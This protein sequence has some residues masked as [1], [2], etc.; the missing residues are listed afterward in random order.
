[1]QSETF[2]TFEQAVALKE[3]GFD[4][5]CQSYYA[6][7]PDGRPDL[8]ISGLGTIS[9]LDLKGRDTLAPTQA[10]AQKWLRDVKGVHVL[11]TLESVNRPYYVCHITQLHSVAKR[12]TDDVKYFPTYEAALSAGID[13]ALELIKA[14]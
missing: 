5:P 4:W 3:C 12:I 1:M 11:P 8:W 13:A 9:G 6:V 2:V 7:E 14:K 10:L